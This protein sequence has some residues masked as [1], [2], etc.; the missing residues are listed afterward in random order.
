MLDIYL[1]RHA[2]SEMNKN[3]HLI[4]G[5]SNSTPL[6]QKGINQAISLGKRLKHSRVI[7][8]ELYSSTAKRTLETARKV[9]EHMGFSQDNVIKT[10]ELLE[11]DQGEWEGKPREQIYTPEVLTIIEGDNWNFTPPNGESQKDLEERLQKMIYRI[12][13]SKNSQEKTIGI[14]T[15]GMAIKCLLRGIMDFH[16]SLTYKVN[17]DNTSIT[18]LKYDKK[19]WHL[20]TINDTAHL[21][22]ND[23]INDIDISTQ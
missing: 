23:K 15:H 6:S 11:L 20:I 18:R 3:E 13:T 16:S 21:F 19:G 9:G 22:R 8:D 7:F 14:F 1:I 17:L 4:G 5:R 10:S 12:L 2:E